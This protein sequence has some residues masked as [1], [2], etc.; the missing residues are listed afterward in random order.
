MIELRPAVSADAPALARVHVQSWAETYQGLMPD[1]FLSGMTS[2]TMQER[3]Q[4]LWTQTLEEGQDV[5]LVAVQGGEVVGF[6]SG[7][8]TDFAGY[9]AELFTLYLLKSAQGTG[10]GRALVRELAQALGAAGHASLLLWVLNVNPTRG[11]YERLGGVLIGEKT[12][13]V[14][15]G[16]LREV[17]YGWADVGALA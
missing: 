12:V 14:R 2:Q 9:D 1:G 5:V 15:G 3:R 7:G 10:I 4:T 11:F 6:A 8:P 17:A 13:S 16:E